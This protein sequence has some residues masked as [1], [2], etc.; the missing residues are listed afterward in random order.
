[1]SRKTQ[2]EGTRFQRQVNQ[3]S[4]ECPGKERLRITPRVVRLGR[5]DGVVWHGLLVSRVCAN[6]RRPRPTSRPCH[7]ADRP[8]PTSATQQTDH[9]QQGRAT[10]PTGRATQDATSPAAK[11]GH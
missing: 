10:R 3:S 9:G 7:T 2:S 4:V 8:R 11:R 6:R 1:L 5:G